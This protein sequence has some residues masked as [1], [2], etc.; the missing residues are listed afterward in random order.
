M[1][2]RTGAPG[3]RQGIVVAMR[4]YDVA[5]TI[6]L[7]EIEAITARVAP[8][9]VTRIRLRRAD[10]KAIAFGVPPIEVGL[11]PIELELDGTWY[12]I[13]AIARIYDFGVV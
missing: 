13:D 8:T 6:D 10:P 5:D 7:T 9:A 4:L 12:T 3:V 11:R 1:A 2:E